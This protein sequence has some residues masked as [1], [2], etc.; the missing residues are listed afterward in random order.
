M[1]LPNGDEFTVNLQAET[2][3]DDQLK[4]LTIVG[5]AKDIV[6]ESIRNGKFIGWPITTASLGCPTVCYSRVVSRKRFPCASLPNHCRGL[7]SRLR[8]IQGHQ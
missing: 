5:T 3:F 6:I 1:V 4:T 2:V 8:P 7:V